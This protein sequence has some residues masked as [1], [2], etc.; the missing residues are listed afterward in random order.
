[1]IQNSAQA[2][3]VQLKGTRKDFADLSLKV[4]KSIK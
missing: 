1:M 2:P 4:Q 3:K